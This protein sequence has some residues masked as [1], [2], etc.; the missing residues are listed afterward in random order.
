MPSTTF[1]VLASLLL[2]AALQGCASGPPEP[3]WPDTIVS[4]D[5]MRPTTPWQVPVP[6]PEKDKVR[7][8]SRNSVVVLQV[9]V[10]TDG[11]V[12][13][14]RVTESSNNPVLDAA[15]LHTMRALRFAPYRIAGVAQAVTVLATTR[16]PFYDRD[17]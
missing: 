14:A 3:V 7:D 4:I 9:F 1:R 16:F 13:Q 10:G 5:D 8:R 15:A 12:V 17:R 2:A 6:P 11:A